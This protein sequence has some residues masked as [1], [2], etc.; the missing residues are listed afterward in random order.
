L[1]LLPF[2]VGL[3]KRAP[4]ELRRLS[5]A[6]MIPVA[7][8]FAGFVGAIKLV[9]L[10]GSFL[11]GVTFGPWGLG[12]P[13][14]DGT[15][16]ELF[17][18]PLLLPLEVVALVAALVLLIW[19]RRAWEPSLLGTAGIMLAALS[20]SQ[21]LPLLA[22]AGFFDRYFVPV[23]APLSPLVAAMVST[24]DLRPRLSALA[25]VFFLSVGVLIYVVGQQDYTSWQAARDT[26][27]RRA[28]TI[29][30][31]SEVDA[32]YEKTAENIWVPAA[33]D[34]TLPQAVDKIPVIYL[35]FAGPDDSRPGVSYSSLAPGR[36]VI[37]RAR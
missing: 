2:G 21:F 28:Y 22:Y 7:I 18:I 29:A 5:R 34:R 6:E 16:V 31:A 4:E 11:P 8:A 20:I 23:A 12:P 15:K 10:H 9:A 33:N 27:T 35:V 30:P 26:A 3:L 25:A 19:R 14:V 1:L 24:S 13:S 17:P 32:G 37:L 36:I